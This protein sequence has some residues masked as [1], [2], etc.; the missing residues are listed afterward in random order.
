MARHLRG[1][2]VIGMAKLMA[3]AVTAVCL[4]LLACLLVASPAQAGS[5]GV[6]YSSLR[7]ASNWSNVR[8]T[9]GDYNTAAVDIS[10]YGSWSAPNTIGGLDSVLVACD[11]TYVYFSFLATGNPLDYPAAATAQISNNYCFDAMLNTNPLA[12]S[13]STQ[14]FAAS[15]NGKTNPD[16]IVL[17]KNI[18][19]PSG[20]TLNFLTLGVFTRSGTQGVA[21]TTWSD[22]TGNC[23]ITDKGLTCP[24][25]TETMVEIEYRMPVSWLVGQTDLQNQPIT[26]STPIRAFY[27]TSNNAN[28][29]NKDYMAGSS[30]DF[31][32]V[33]PFTL[34]NSD[35]WGVMNDT[36]DGAPPSN[37]GTWYA[38][39]TLLVNGWGW[40]Y[41]IS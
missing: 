22:S 21:G 24:G 40:P 26:T 33:A 1:L 32:V 17:I 6:N 28:N 8:D 30:L 3:A 36:R 41:S 4:S 15:L 23:I 7:N 25:A 11:G 13:T 14:D 2:Q 34:G 9:T 19:G 5:Y 38:Y 31:T 29:I 35:A 39:E 37:A 10:S 27:G 20:T 12:T 18:G 16:Q